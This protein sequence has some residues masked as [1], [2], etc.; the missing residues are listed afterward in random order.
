MEDVSARPGQATT[1]ALSR[2]ELNPQP[3][4]SCHELAKLI[5]TLAP[6]WPRLEAK[7]MA[8][9]FEMRLMLISERDF[10]RIEVL[11]SVLE[12]DMHSRTAAGLL[13]LSLRQVQ[14]LIHAEQQGCIA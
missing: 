8:C 6:L 12:N 9:G 7:V 14:R 13:G 11:A 1:A 5:G 4:W 10:Q 2:F 3:K